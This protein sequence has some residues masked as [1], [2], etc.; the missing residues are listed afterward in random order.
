MRALRRRTYASGSVLIRVSAKIRR[1]HHPVRYSDYSGVPRDI[2]MDRSHSS[3][4]QPP[5]RAGRGH[6]QLIPLVWIV[7]LLASW[8][9]IVDWKMLPDLIS[10]AMG[11]LP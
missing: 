11:A 6:A 4:S 3:G 2:A 9:V 10:A 8:F 5:R 7:V 1:I